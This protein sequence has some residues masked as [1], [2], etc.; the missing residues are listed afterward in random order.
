MFHSWG[1][2]WLKEFV[3][4][5]NVL[6]ITNKFDANTISKQALDNSTFDGKVYGLPLGLSIAEMWYNKDIFAKYN[7][8]PPATWEEF[9]NVVDTLKKK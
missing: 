7:L 9:I 8:K 1:G 3:N 6:E 4:Q 2:G 5:G